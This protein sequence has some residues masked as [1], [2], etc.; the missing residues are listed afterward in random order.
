MP[1]IN[2]RAESGAGTPSSK[3]TLAARLV[4]GL[5]RGEVAAPALTIAA[6]TAIVRLGSV[7]QELTV[8]WRFGTGDDLDAFLISVLVPS[9]IINVTAS[10][11]NSAFIP[12]YVRVRQRE[13]AEAA[14]EL[15]RR[16]MGWAL[17]FLILIAS[18][19][20]AGAPLYLPRIG[21]GFSSEKLH[22][23]FRLLYLG[24]PIVVISGIAAV[25]S[26]ALNAEQRFII[27]AISPLATP[28]LTVGLLW[29]Q[30]SWRSL[31]LV[32]GLVGGRSTEMLLL[33]IALKRR[34]LSLRPSWPHF[35]ENMRRLV[36]QYAPA[37]SG[38]ILASAKPMVDQAMA[39]MLPAGSVS[40]LNY[41]NRIV[42]FPILLVATALGTA[43]TP[44]FSRL[45]AS[46][47]WDELHRTIRRS[48]RLTLL[49]T[50]PL[51]LCLFVFSEPLVDL[52]F[53]RGAFT[54][55][56]AHL[57]ARIQAF[58]AIQIPFYIGGIIVVRLIAAVQ[59]N[60]IV[61]WVSSINLAINITLNYLFMRWMGVAGIALSTSVVYMFSVT[62]CY[63]FIRGK[64]PSAAQR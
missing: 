49:F 57:V 5:A 1:A 46:E 50:G 64:M 6:L 56:D 8:A 21:S 52:V 31:A 51:A 61:L 40:A 60:R 58:Y 12:A 20:V 59:A 7:G 10:S 41:G 34:S 36:T 53:R 23:T 35:D 27:P 30:P 14:Q 19:I 17:V 18:L 4:N 44:Y 24:A 45:A 42:Q 43:L 38:S 29:L 32:V 9:A 15:F 48:L 47:Y 55:N 37:I 11:F 54:A 26:A 33:G 39:A 25:W 28:I 2:Q 3:L 63:L 13:G 22:L 62:L 16:V